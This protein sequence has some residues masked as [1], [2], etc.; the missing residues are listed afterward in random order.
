MAEQMCS[1]GE[2]GD[3]PGDVSPCTQRQNLVGIPPSRQTPSLPGSLLQSGASGPG[4][5]HAGSFGLTKAVD[6]EHTRTG[7]AS[8]LT[9]ASSDLLPGI[10]LLID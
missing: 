10:Y 8:L 2:K 1:Y 9:C 6:V 3:F 5:G 7:T 4:I